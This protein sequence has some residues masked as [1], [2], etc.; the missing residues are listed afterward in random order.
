MAITIPD[1]IRSV[2]PYA[3]HRFSN[4]INRFNRII[5]GGEDTILP[6]DDQEF[7][8]TRKTTAGSETIAGTVYTWAANKAV[9]V[10]PGMCIKD[11]M[12]IHIKNSSYVNFSDPTNY[13]GSGTGFNAFDTTGKYFILLSYTYA[14][15]I[16]APQASIVIAKQRS[17]FL[18]NRD[19]YIYLGTATVDYTS[20]FIVSGVSLTDIDELNSDTPITRPNYEFVVPFVDGGDLDT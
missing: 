3:D 10:G 9:K 20:T 13:V 6:F 2:D 7:N 19:R 14:R 17:E 11:D 18:N 16:P 4:T 8:L 5:T 1:Q 12:L 15:S